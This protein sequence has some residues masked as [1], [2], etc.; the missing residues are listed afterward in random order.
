MTPNENINVCILD[1]IY[2]KILYMC[3]E[4]KRNTGVKTF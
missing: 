3:V 2:L 4:D 1:K